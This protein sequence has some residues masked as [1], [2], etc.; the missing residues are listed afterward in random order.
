MRLLWRNRHFTAC[1]IAHLLHG[2]EHIYPRVCVDNWI[3]WAQL[4]LLHFIFVFSLIQF[5]KLFRHLTSVPLCICIC[6]TERRSA[7][8]LSSQT[9]KELHLVRFQ[10][11]FTSFWVHSSRTQ[12]SS[13]CETKSGTLH[14]LHH[15]LHHPPDASTPTRNSNNVSTD[16][17]SHTQCVTLWHLRGAAA[18]LCIFPAIT[19]VAVA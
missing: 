9:N 8:T 1:P 13:C 10:C 18:F 6:A 7:T 15:P 16:V 17:A 19:S 3:S 5:N 11:I 4:L 12:C 14:P 2:F